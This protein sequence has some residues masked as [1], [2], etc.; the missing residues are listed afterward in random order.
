MNHDA[1]EFLLGQ[2]REVEKLIDQIKIAAPNDRGELF[3]ELRKSLAVHETAE[4]LILRPVTK[5]ISDEG[6]A[7][8]DAR[9]AEENEAKRSLAELEKLDPSTEA[10]LADFDAFASDVLEHAN[11][12]ETQEF[13]LVRESNDADRLQKLGMA[14]EKVEKVAPTHPHPAAKSAAV[15]VVVGPFASI[16]DRARDAIS[17]A[18]NH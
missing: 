4:E 5:S 15:T 8:A 1:I 17:G 14:M 7:M 3:D 13:P 10:F 6:L 11:N 18:L 16:V 12:E 9:I 2:H